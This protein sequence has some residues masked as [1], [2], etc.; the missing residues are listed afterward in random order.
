MQEYL[1]YRRDRF[2]IPCEDQDCLAVYVVVRKCWR[3][4]CDGNHPTI[5]QLSG[6]QKLYVAS[7]IS[8]CQG[9][10]T[11]T[12]WQFSTIQQAQLTKMGKRIRMCDLLR[13]GERLSS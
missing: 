1:D 10:W 6:G 8:S 3:L 5:I 9:N 13:Y 12:K 11:N 2:P 7:P 4:L